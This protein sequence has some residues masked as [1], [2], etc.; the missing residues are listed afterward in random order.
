MPT[1]PSQPTALPI[2]SFPSPSRSL[3][4][5]AVPSS[6]PHACPMPAPHLPSSFPG[7]QLQTAAGMRNPHPIPAPT[8]LSS[9][10]GHMLCPWPLSAVP[11]CSRL[12]SWQASAPLE[13]AM[14]TSFVLCPVG[15]ENANV[16]LPGPSNFKPQVTL[17]ESMPT[18]VCERVHGAPYSLGT[19]TATL[20]IRGL[21]RWN[22][23]L[24]TVPGTSDPMQCIPPP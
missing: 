4:R 10:T 12:L 7:Q 22:G 13:D 16:M 9:S 8:P 18:V 6:L 5:S 14:E 19:C 3:W 15:G 11:A 2:G 21:R 24:D 17:G 1:A 20:Y 23:L